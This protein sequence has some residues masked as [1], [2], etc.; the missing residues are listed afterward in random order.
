MNVLCPQSFDQGLSPEERFS[1]RDLIKKI[2]E[3]KEELGLIIDLTYTTRYYGPEVGLCLAV[4]E[5]KLS[6]RPGIA[7]EVEGVSC[8]RTT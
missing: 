3:Q 1:P 5:V 4:R 2:K 6:A 7:G 8:K